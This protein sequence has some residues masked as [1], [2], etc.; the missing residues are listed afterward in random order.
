MAD[1]VVRIDVAEG[2]SPSF[3]TIQEVC[4]TLLAAQVNCDLCKFE[5]DSRER[6]AGHRSGHARRG[7]LAKKLPRSGKHECKYCNRDFPSGRLGSHIRG[8][9]TPEM[10]AEKLRTG[11]LGSKGSLRFIMIRM[12]RKF[13]CELCGQGPVWNNQPLMLQVDHHDGNNQNNTPE[14][15]RFL[16]PNCHT[17]TPTYS[18]KK[19]IGV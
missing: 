5:T 4:C 12:G 11:R 14:N 7:E 3:P 10:L 1:S 2:S 17:Q 18:N 6:Y 15:L 13:E 16:C 8:C 9:G 19:R